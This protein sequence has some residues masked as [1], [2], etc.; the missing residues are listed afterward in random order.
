MGII[1]HPLVF[2]KQIDHGLTV[3]IILHLSRST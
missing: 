2:G 1:T 3:Q